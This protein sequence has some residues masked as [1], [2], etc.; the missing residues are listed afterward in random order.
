MHT[1]ICIY[2]NIDIFI[3]IDYLYIYIYINI[4][5][6]IYNYIYTDIYIH[7]IAPST[8]PT[9]PISET[10]SPMA[11][12]VF[13]QASKLRGLVGKMMIQATTAWSLVGT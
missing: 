3:Y 10:A 9:I 11:F 13:P 7:Y 8:R 12:T 4:D 1:D 6:Y 2:I 5:T